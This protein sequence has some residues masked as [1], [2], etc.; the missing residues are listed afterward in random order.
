VY[1]T[2]HQDIG[3]M[4]LAD[5]N[6]AAVQSIMEGTQTKPLTLPDGSVLPPTGRR[7]GVRRLNLME[8]DAAGLLQDLV[9][10]DN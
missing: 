9:V 4:Y 10:V 8:F 1:A 7:V 6:R 3:T 5:G 2:D